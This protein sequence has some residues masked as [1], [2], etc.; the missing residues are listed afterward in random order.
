[1]NTV[2]W[3]RY[4]ILH[5]MVTQCK[6]LQDIA[7]N[8]SASPSHA[9]VS[10]SFWLSPGGSS[11]AGGG[12]RIWFGGADTYAAGRDNAWQRL[13]RPGS[14][15]GGHL[16]TGCNSKPVLGLFSTIGLP[17]KRRRRELRI[18][19]LHASGGTHGLLIAL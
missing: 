15:A 6:H 8:H 12:Y 17:S 14:G 3:T 13:S 19:L 11:G 5:V 7:D 16:L 10:R 2:E 1:V 18:V 4:L 9:A